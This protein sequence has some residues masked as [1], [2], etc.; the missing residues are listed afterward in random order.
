MGLAAFEPKGL[1]PAMRAAGRKNESS[2]FAFSP[3]RKGGKPSQARIDPSL[4]LLKES[5]QA[6]TSQNERKNVALP[7][8]PKGL[9]FPYRR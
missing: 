3:Y 4:D 7:T 1:W 6:S 5:Y 9:R 8:V 2:R